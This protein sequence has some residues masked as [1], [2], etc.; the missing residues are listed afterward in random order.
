MNTFFLRVGLLS[1]VLMLLLPA[2]AMGKEKDFYVQMISEIDQQIKGMV[3]Q[4][5]SITQAQKEL[6]SWTAQAGVWIDQYNRVNQKM[7][8]AEQRAGDY[9]TMGGGQLDSTLASLKQELANIIAPPGGRVVGNTRYPSLNEV[10]VDMVEKGK[11]MKTLRM[12][13]N[14]LTDELLK[15]DHQR[16]NFVADARDGLS[17]S[18]SENSELLQSLKKSFNEKSAIVKDGEIWCDQDRPPNGAL[19]EGPIYCRDRKM[20]LTIIVAKY[21]REMIRTGKK[22]SQKEM[23]DIV[24]RAQKRSNWIK[25]LIKSN[26]LPRL[27]EA[28]QKRKTQKLLFTDMVLTGC[29]RLH[30]PQG[31]DHAMLNIHEVGHEAYQAVLTKR[32][33]LNYDVGHVL[34]VV[35]RVNSTTFDGTE[36]SVNNNRWYS[37]P[38]R[39]IVDRDRSGASYR[40]RDDMIILSPCSKGN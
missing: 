24:Q 20:A 34:F 2:G 17:L 37:T 22:Y 28:L 30:D 1:F 18:F 40:T 7:I 11:E 36:T 15:I 4:Q 38:L 10:Q 35:E 31:Y 32:G 14:D 27:K 29:W 8:K 6:D 39:I 26:E 25:N 5:K 16:D 9:S 19:G 33:W 23:V 12:Q 13:Y 3:I 21:R